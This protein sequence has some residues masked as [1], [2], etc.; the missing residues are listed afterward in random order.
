MPTLQ[1]HTSGK[2]SK[3]SH[4]KQLNEPSLVNDYVA[5]G[6]IMLPEKG[7]AIKR[8]DGLR[9]IEQNGYRNKEKK[10]RRY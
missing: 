7:K 8:Y 2:F 4:S 9:Y 5:A 1:S 6:A 10:Q 3:P